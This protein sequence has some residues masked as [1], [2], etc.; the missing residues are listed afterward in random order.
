MKVKVVKLALLV[1][2]L[3]FS[4]NL[5]AAIDWDIYEN[6]DINSGEY[7]I[8][9]VYQSQDIPPIQTTVNVYGGTITRLSSLDDSIIN[10]Y[11]GTI[12]TNVGAAEN[13]TVNLH[14][15]SISEAWVQDNGTLNIYGYDF[16]TELVGS[17]AHTLLTGY[18]LDGTELSILFYREYS[19]P[20]QVNLLPE[21]ISILFLGL[22][23]VAL[24]KR[25]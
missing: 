25:K 13:S 1:S 23:F 10:I 4:S 14:G 18:W 21:P 5:T 22:G 9:N 17:G 24:R 15:G 8:V 20:E 19:L 2:I 6:T 7:S 11:G 16:E 12:G 3:I